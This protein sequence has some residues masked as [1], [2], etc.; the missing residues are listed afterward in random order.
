MKTHCKR[1]HERTP[2]NVNNIGACIACLK[3][4]NEAKRG[5]RKPNSEYMKKY[6]SENKEEQLQASR[7]RYKNDSEF[8]TKSVK[9]S[10]KSALKKLGWTPESVEETREKQNNCCALCNKPFEATPHAD[11][12]HLTNLPRELLCGT[13]NQA[14]GMLQE[15]PTLCEAA[16][17]YLRKWGK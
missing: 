3:L 11:H 9:R 6:Y 5:K 15:S 8:R 12:D 14:L 7:K 1:G 4:K 17:A 2:D 13:C 10:R 16:A